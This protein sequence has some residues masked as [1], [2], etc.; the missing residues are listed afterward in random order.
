MHVPQ[1][2]THDVMES[3]DFSDVY[4]DFFLNKMS[5]F[6]LPFSNEYPESPTLTQP[7]FVNVQPSLY[8]QFHLFQFMTVR[9]L[10][11]C[12]EVRLLSETNKDWNI[13]ITAC[14]IL[15]WTKNPQKKLMG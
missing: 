3:R 13:A 14:E 12:T 10:I 11:L 2:T 8:K 9:G 4:Y 1:I 7:P 6:F 15:L 5:I